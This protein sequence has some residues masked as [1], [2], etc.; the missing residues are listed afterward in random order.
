MDG[1]SVEARTMYIPDRRRAV[2]L[3]PQ[4]ES[5]IGPV[6]EDEGLYSPLDILQYHLEQQWF[7][8]VGWNGLTQKVEMAIAARTI[9]YPLC[10]VVSFAYVGGKNVRAWVPFYLSVCEGWAKKA[11]CT[12]SMGGFRRGWVR[13]AGY[14]EVGSKMVKDL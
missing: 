14:R 9:K 3:W 13:L 11:G 6:I 12:K 8:F 10:K 2:L 4:I 5:W 1:A 7:I